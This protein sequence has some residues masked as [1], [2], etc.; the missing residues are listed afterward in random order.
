MPPINKAAMKAYIER[1]PKMEEHFPKMF[2]KQ[3]EVCKRTDG[4]LRCSGCNT[5]Y[6]CGREHQVADRATHKNTCKTI[7]SAKTKVDEEEAKLRANTAG[8]DDDTPPNVLDTQVGK[9]WL[10]RAARPYMTALQMYAEVLTRS[11]RQQGIEDALSVY[12]NMLRLNNGDNQGAR[13][14]IPGLYIRLG[15]DQKA[16]D[17]LKYWGLQFNSALDPDQTFLG[18]QGADATEGVDLWTG[19]YL[20]LTHAVCVQLIK[21]RLLIG[22]QSVQRVKA[23]SPGKYARMSGAEILDELRDQLRPFCG[24]ILER[25]PEVLGD[26]D[27][28]AKKLDGIYDQINKLFTAVSNYNKY[29]WPMLMQPEEKD[30]SFEPQMYT[31]GSPEEA[32]NTIIQTYPAW[33]ETPG[34]IEGVRNVMLMSIDEFQ[35]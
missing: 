15:R 14:I 3:C 32:R 34:A 33:C 17:F 28:I 1:L 4:L 10:W 9:L 30:L 13:Y 27:L 31:P 5:Y 25:T 18:I 2:P 20:F 35:D 6:Y 11:W 7:K 24:D 21:V 22:L 26:D 19:K 8:G 23:S 16:Y 12:L 29:F